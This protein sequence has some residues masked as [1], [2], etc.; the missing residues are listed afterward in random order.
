MTLTEVSIIIGIV[1]AILGFLG[2]I[3]RQGKSEQ[4]VLSAIESLEKSQ[5]QDRARMA[6]VGQKL[7]AHCTI[8]GIHINPLLDQRTYE[9]QRDWRRSVNEKLDKL[10]LK[11][12]A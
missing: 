4:K 2:M 10:L 9:E 8:D 5:A 1:V 7:D 11:D 3:Y 6:E 12:K